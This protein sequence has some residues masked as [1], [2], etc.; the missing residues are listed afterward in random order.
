[1]FNVLFEPKFKSYVIEMSL[2]ENRTSKS[3]LW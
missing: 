3:A 2:D 1:M